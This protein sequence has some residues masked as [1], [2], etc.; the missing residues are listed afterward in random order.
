MVPDGEPTERQVTDMYEHILLPIDPDSEESWAHALPEAL[1]IASLNRAE[2]TVMSVVPELSTVVAQAAKFSAFT[3][4][5]PRGWVESLLE[6]VRE[7][8]EAF[9]AEHVPAEQ[10][11]KT[12]VRSGTIYKEILG[13]AKARTCDLII[14]GSQRPGLQDYLMGPNAAKVVRHATC[15]VLV[16]RK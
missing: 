6:V 12:V 8:L 15:S 10:P 5:S 9:V 11:T 2:L 16:I 14:V 3:D 7:K 4:A 1:S 13:V